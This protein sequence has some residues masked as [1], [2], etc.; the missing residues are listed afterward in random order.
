M[1]VSQAAGFIGVNSKTL[2][3]AI[4]GGAVP[5]RRVGGRIVI[6]RDAL[7]DWLRGEQQG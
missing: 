6:L 2:Y 4:R 7:I 5:A 3:A 1:E